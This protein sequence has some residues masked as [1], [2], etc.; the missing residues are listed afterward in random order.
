[1]KAM[2]LV[3][4]RNIKRLF[5]L[6]LY[7]LAAVV[8]SQPAHGQLNLEPVTISVLPGSPTTADDVVIRHD[9]VFNTGGYSVG[10]SNFTFLDPFHIQID[11]FVRSPNP[12][13]PVTQAFTFL[14]VDSELGMLAPGDYQYTSRVATIPRGQFPDPPT[15]AIFSQFPPAIRTGQF[16]V[17]PEP[18]SL[19]LLAIGGWALTRRQRHP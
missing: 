12:G 19:S 14:K 8:L 3:K 9:L 18:A 1:M 15:D 5:V 16:T 7:A 13:D 11:V 2:K 10:G 6:W 4:H 17:V